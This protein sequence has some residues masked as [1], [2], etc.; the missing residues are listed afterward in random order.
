MKATYGVWVEGSNITSIL[1]PVL[2]EIRVKDAAG[3]GSDTANITVDDSG[4]K[5]K[6]P[7]KGAAIKIALGWEGSASL[8]V[9]EGE[10]DD[11][12]STG[13]RGQ[14]M[15]L[16]IGAKSASA[17]KKTKQPHEKHK[18]K[19][20]LEDAAKDFGKAAG[21]QVKVHP[22]LASIQRD[23]W[24]MTGESFMAW[25]Q[26]TAREIGAT[27]KIMN[28]GG[29]QTAVMVPRSA[30]LSASGKPLATIKATVG[31][32]VI[33]WSMTPNMPRPSFK[34]FEV[35][36]YDRK[37]AKWVREQV[38][39]QP[40]E[41]V[42]DVTYLDRDTAHDKDTAKHRG[43]SRKKGS[44]REQGGGQVTIDGDPTAQAEAMCVLSG[45]RAGVDGQYRIESVE[46]TYS[47]SGGF[48]T[49]LELKQPAGDAGK[50]D[51]KPSDGK[52]GGASPA[53]GKSDVTGRATG[54]V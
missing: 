15:M 26:R 7:R 17:T 30:G 38:D 35:R 9:F 14:G 13:G 43:K 3:S 2:T 10:V 32:N 28:V 40:V 47:R 44:E 52:D 50:D 4:G 21:L 36:Y 46:H 5:I 45:A 41:G 54:Q 18:A 49:Q 11:V 25:G 53:I 51:R 6:M 24:G 8:V 48:T 20:S 33:S 19:A 42:G 34:K 39:G 37:K 29:Q 31:V 22:E 23:W 1:D 27:F 16:E 12:R